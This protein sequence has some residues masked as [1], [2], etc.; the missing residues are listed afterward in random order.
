MDFD[1]PELNAGLFQSLQDR[2]SDLGETMPLRKLA[3]VCTRTGDRSPVSC[4]ETLE[5]LAERLV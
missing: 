4:V 3:R 2:I 1:H 5:A